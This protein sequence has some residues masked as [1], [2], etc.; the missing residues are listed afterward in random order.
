MSVRSNYGIEIKFKL[1]EANSLRLCLY[2]EFK[3]IIL[4]FMRQLRDMVDL[5]EAHL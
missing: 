5:T 2:L 4:K 1:L 3:G